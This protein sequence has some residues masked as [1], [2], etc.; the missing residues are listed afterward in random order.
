MRICSWLGVPPQQFLFSSEE[1]GKSTPEIVSA[2]L[3]AD[4]TLPPET[5]DALV[6]MIHLAHHLQIV[7]LKPA[8]I[9]RITEDTLRALRNGRSEWSALTIQPDGQTFVIYNPNHSLAG[10]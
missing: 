10:C 9:P 1:S 7:L 4:K 5:A 8:Q 3:R 6:Q 2:H